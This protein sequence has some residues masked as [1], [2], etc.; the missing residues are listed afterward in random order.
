MRIVFFGAPKS[1][2]P[3]LEGLLRADHSIELVIT[4]PDRPSGRGKHL[5]PCPVKR[6]ASGKK[7]P[8]FQPE[9][10]RHDALALETINSARPDIN[11]VVAY[12][13]ILPRSIIDLP[14]HRSVNVHFSLLPK[15]RGASPVQ[16]AI[17]NGEQKTGLTIFVL[18]EKMDEG[19][20]L[21]QEDM[22]IRPREK[23]FELE[24]RL[25]ERGAALLVRTLREID[26]TTPVP[27]NHALATYAPKLRKKDGQV[28]WTKTAELIGRQV[29]ALSP[30][31][32]AF[33]FAGTTRIKI[34]EGEPLP[35]PE[36]RDSSHPGQV[37]AVRKEG[38][39]VS[40]G[41]GTVFLI[42]RL[43]PE[44]KK[45]ME[46]YAFSL[47]SKIKIGDVLR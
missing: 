28:D 17:L 14:P 5:V 29:R 47:G 27:Q 34:I 7:I 31:P 35:L 1:A 11:V 22:D 13:Q 21:A 37:I 45:E 40:C 20:I 19:D 23:A 30:W 26:R 44:G 4:Q 18:N 36:Q 43:Q 3:S 8:V 39:E 32:S 16:W 33:T 6:F 42:A 25:A 10:I 24:S 12:G 41:S 38:F 2:L 46:A 15:Y 9:K